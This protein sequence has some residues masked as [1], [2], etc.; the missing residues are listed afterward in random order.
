M[1]RVN[2]EE[3]WWTDPRR[4]KLTSLVGSEE[5]AD[6]IAVSFWRVAQEYYGAGRKPIPKEIFELLPAAQHLVDAKVARVEDA[7]VVASGGADLFDWLVGKRAAAKKGGQKSAE[8]RRKKNGTAQPK[9]AEIPEAPP[10]HSRSTLELKGSNVE[11]SGSGSG[12]GSGSEI[13]FPSETALATQDAAPV[14]KFNPVA[15][16]CSEYKRHYGFSPITTGKDR[17]MLFGQARQCSEAGMQTLFAAYLAM[18][19]K[20]YCEQKH[21]LSLY[22]RDLNKIF[23]AAKTGIDPSQ[24][25]PIDWKKVYGEGDG[26]A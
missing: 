18:K 11:P 16:W 13:T 7:G 19:D 23:A 6:G 8:S 3:S 5:L 4:K 17:G 9:K 26:A 20:L 22:F 2:I 15:L 1:A 12:S 21:P 10:K 14:G 24:P 25:A